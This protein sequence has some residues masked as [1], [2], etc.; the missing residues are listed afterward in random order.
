[1]EIEKAFKRL[2]IKN[3][4]Y[5]LFC[6]SLP[7][8][9]TT[10]IPTLCVTKKGIN[11]ELNIN[12]DFWEQHTDDEQI[13]LLQHE[14]SHICL[15]HIFISE[16][17][18]DHHTFN[19]AADMEVNSYIENLPSDACRASSIG[20]ADGQGSKYYYE[21]LMQQQQ[22]QQAQNPQKPCNGGQGGNSPQSQASAQQGDDKEDG[23]SGD[24]QEEKKEESQYPDN[25]KN[26]FKAMDS[27]E[28]WK[29]FKNMPEATKQLM[30]NNIASIVKNTAEQ[31]ERQCGTIP[32]EL[33]EMIEKL[34]KKKP[35]IFNW[36]AYF[37]RMLG[38]IYDVNIKTTRRKES[39]RFEG[40]AG[41]QHKKKVSI[42]VAIDTSGSVSSKELQDFFSE[43]DWI[44]KA[45]AR[46][47][48]IE[49]DA[50]INKIEEY[51]GKHI[52]EIV[53]RGGTDFNPPVNYYL[54]H[55]KEYASLIYFTDGECNLPE[56]KPSGMVWV[57]TS[58]GWRQEYPGKTIYIPK[59]ND[60]E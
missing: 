14:L 15:Q 55:R 40:A 12:P 21:K 27:H 38:S 36:K 18:A 47:T 35:E 45:G 6:L 23:D 13:A 51:D 20:L 8:N 41:V 26:K 7:K 30:Q 2:L 25:L 28:S 56:K 3:P 22:Q 29:E 31:V 4:F 24:N 60:E 46:V 43:I 11:C 57:I 37:R 33:R 48:I 19:A 9:I 34:R 1:M 49:C 39:K 32:A 54:K 59:S 5:G 17:F 50:R 10:S 44:Y 52:P 53:G 42:L 58:N 16:S